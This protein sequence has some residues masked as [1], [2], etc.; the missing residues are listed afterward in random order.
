MSQNV[1]Y[2][3]PFVVNNKDVVKTEILKDADI[4]II[5]DSTYLILKYETDSVGMLNWLYYMLNKES[6]IH[7]INGKIV[8]FKIPLS[9]KIVVDMVYKCGIEY[10]TSKSMIKCCNFWN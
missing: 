9:L 8:T 3:I 6:N 10:M 5:G 4:N 7:T 1:K 2:A